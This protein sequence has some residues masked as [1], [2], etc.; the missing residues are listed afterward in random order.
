MS[1]IIGIVAHAT[2]GEATPIHNICTTRNIII[3]I[4]CFAALR[5]DL[6]HA[7]KPC[8]LNLLALFY[9]FVK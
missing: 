5:T 3:F 8:K 7:V 9:Y 6:E 4:M 2:K 1:T